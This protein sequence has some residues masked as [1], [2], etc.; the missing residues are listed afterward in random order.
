MISFPVSYLVFAAL[1]FELKSQ[2][3]LSIVLSPLFWFASFF[4]V[5]TGLGLRELKQWSWYTLHAAQFF[6]TFLNALNLL[7]YS[8]SDFKAY[9]FILTLGIQFF[10]YLIIERELRV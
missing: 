5:M 4:W 10:V 3:T 6:I 7:N 9:A 2:G 8:H 1:V